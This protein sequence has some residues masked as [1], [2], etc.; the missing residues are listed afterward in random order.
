MENMEERVTNRGKYKKVWYVLLHI[1][2]IYYINKNVDILLAGKINFN[3]KKLLELK[4]S[5]FND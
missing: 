4:S 3:E 2:C 1:P 5:L